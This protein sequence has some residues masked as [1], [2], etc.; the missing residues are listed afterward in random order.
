MAEENTIT[1]IFRANIDQFSASTQDMKRYMGQV[2]AE[3]AEATAGMGKWSDSTDGLSAKLKQLDGTLQAQKKQLSALESEYESLTDEQKKN[4]AQGQKLA[5]SILKQRADVKK[6]ESQIDSYSGALKELTDAG[7]ETRKELDDLNKKMDEN[8]NTASS[9]AGK[10]AGGLGKGL[11]GLSTAVVGAGAS[12]LGIAENTRE[13]R[14]EQG[15]LEASFVSAGHSAETANK[16][17][18]DFNAVLGDTAK[19]TEAM[20]QLAQFTKNEQ[21]LTA[22]TDILTGAFATFGN[23]LPTEGLAEGIN[24]TIQLGEVQGTLADALEWSGVSV[25]DFNKQLANCN[26]EEERSALIQKTLNGLY[27]DASKQY[28][29]NNKDIIESEKAQT[30]LTLAMAE[31]GKVAE[32]IANMLK[33]TFAGVLEAILP[34]VQLMGEGLQEAFSGSEEGAQKFAEG[35][36]GMVESL[37][38]KATEILPSIIGVVSALFPTL[39]T[40]IADNLPTI[41]NAVIEGFTQVLNALSDMLPT[42]IPVIVDA[43]LACANTILDNLDIIINAGIQIILS[44]AEGLIDALPK[45]LD[46]VPLIIGRL[47]GGLMANLPKLVIA[48]IELLLQLGVGLIKAIPQV[49]AQI[50]LIIAGI[51]D[52]LINGI[53]DLIK[54]GGDMLKGVFEGFLNP[55]VIFEKIKE[56]GNSIVSN[57]KKF[58]GIHSPSKL[59]EDEI[60]KNLALGI[61]E[62]FDD[63]VGKVNSEMQKSLDKMTPTLGIDAKAFPTMPFV[64]APA[65]WLDKLAD[66]VVAKNQVINNNYNF[67]YKFEKMETSKLALHKA[68]LETKRAI[69]G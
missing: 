30:R 32:P 45:L 17:Y 14:K 8:G 4:T 16:V 42:L 5:T 61:G 15:Q 63:E 10:I 49:V 43:V 1:T 60:G 55:K 51:V 3:F 53:P 62:G 66:L 21:E 35:F 59:F 65:D 47:V 36:S 7:V 44:L 33:S 26:T 68:T 28:K 12:F 40:T 34:F 18:T 39:I 27:G 31:L 37:L 50:P 46:K 13:F 9:V 52:G 64:G 6:T 24:H 29:E 69:G 23:A 20:Q 22:Y 19:T 38:T 11:L 67:A 2:N 56:F 58:F 54:T 57:V 25:E 48:G 41:L